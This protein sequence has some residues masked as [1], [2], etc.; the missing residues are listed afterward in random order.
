MHILY[1]KSN[2]AYYV[3]IILLVWLLRVLTATSVSCR[4]S[5]LYTKSI[6]FTKLNSSKSSYLPCNHLFPDL[7][8]D[9]FP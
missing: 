9:F 1:Q 7:S 5:L 8:C 4:Q 3:L 2:T 6:K